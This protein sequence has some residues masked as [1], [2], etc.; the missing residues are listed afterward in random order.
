MTC[1]QT[2]S[3]NGTSNA[4]GA[5]SAGCCSEQ[6]SA[7][8]NGCAGSCK[9]ASGGPASGMTSSTSE[10]AEIEASPATGEPSRLWCPGR[11]AE[12]AQCLLHE[13]APH[14]KWAVC[15]NP[16]RVEPSHPCSFRQVKL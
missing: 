15:V 10:S 13:S 5:S 11:H 9:G 6:T 3:M 14:P 7:G 8:S 16:D 1:H 2:K 12:C 4:A